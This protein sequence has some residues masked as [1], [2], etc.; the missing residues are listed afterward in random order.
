MGS[1]AGGHRVVVVGYAGAL[2]VELLAVRDLF[3]LASDLQVGDGRDPAYRVEIASVD[4]GPIDLGRGLTLAGVLSLGA[5]TDPIDTLVVIGGLTAPAIAAREPGLVAAVA[6]SAARST[7]VVSVCTGAFLLA[8]AG[9]LDGR[10]ATTHWGAAQRLAEDHPA[11]SVEPDAIYLR[12]GEVW[13][14]A[15]VTAAIDLVLALVEEDLGADRAVEVA[16][17]A[18]VFLRRP[19]GQSQFSVHL[20]LPRTRRRPVRDVA[21]HVLAHPGADLSLAALADHVN[22]SPR[23]LARLFRAEVG[24][25]LGHYVDRVRLDAARR[26]VEAGDRPLAAVAAE[27]GLGTAENLRRVFVATLGVAPADYRRRFGAPTS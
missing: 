2:G 9:L 5:D 24:V 3:D 27:T 14:S 11:V 12:D 10:R 4:G 17:L 16:R 15:G 22:L 6:A 23:H 18:V 20:D 7:R 26:A 21:H 1:A 8:A 13:T 19:G 25:S